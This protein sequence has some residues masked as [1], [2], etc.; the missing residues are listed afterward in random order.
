[1]VHHAAVI[2]VPAH[3]HELIV[4]MLQHRISKSRR[5]RIYGAFLA[6]C[7]RRDP[8]ARQDVVDFGMQFLQNGRDIEAV[9]K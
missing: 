3:M 4:A 1:M 7:M 2:V 5:E 6:G 8:D 9:H